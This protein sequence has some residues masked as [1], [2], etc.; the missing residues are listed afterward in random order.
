MRLRV[1][2]I[3]AP[4]GRVIDS[5]VP[6]TDGEAAV[7]VHRW[8]GMIGEDDL[9]VT[10]LD[11]AELTDEHLLEMWGRGHAAIP[12]PLGPPNPAGVELPEQRQ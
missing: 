3:S 5:Q 10:E 2:W 12:E 8:M 4:D 11:K 7:L 1:S 9:I 6:D